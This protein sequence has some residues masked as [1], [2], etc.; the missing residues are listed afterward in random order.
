MSVDILGQCSLC[1]VVW[2]WDLLSGRALL[3]LR[4]PAATFGRGYCVL[5]SG[6]F[7]VSACVERAIVPPIV[8]LLGGGA[9]GC[10]FGLGLFPPLGNG[11]VLCGFL[12]GQ[13]A[14]GFEQGRV[15]LELN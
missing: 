2:I 5:R 11:F 10:R 15:I 4:G 14:W 7:P 6:R 8:L 12:F 13:G 3:S 9:A 1:R